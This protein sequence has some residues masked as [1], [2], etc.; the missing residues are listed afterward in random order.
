MYSLNEPKAP[1]TYFRPDRSQPSFDRTTLEE[2]I[3]A[4]GKV[5][6]DDDHKN[7]SSKIKQTLPCL[8][9]EAMSR[10]HRTNF[11]E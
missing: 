3:Y 7:I 11:I 8:P 6:E 1:A 4:Q 9:F 5:P 10:N 2:G